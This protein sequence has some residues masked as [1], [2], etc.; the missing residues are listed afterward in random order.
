MKH[1]SSS[2]V[3][4]GIHNLAFMASGQGDRRLVGALI[5]SF[6]S[7]GVAGVL[8]ATIVHSFCGHI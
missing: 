6:L 3:V 8:L 4:C 2:G 1:F 7:G 5:V